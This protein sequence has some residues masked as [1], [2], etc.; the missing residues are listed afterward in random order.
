MEEFLL[1]LRIDKPGEYGADGS[2]I[3]DIEDSEEYGRYYSKL[4]NSDL[5][6]E[7]ED[8][9]ILTDSNSSYQFTSEDYTIT[10]TGDL[11]GD[12]YKLDIRKN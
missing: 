5:V 7:Q 9:N 12:V 3:I 4:S 6:E 10:L 1:D 8:S 2:Y 11:L